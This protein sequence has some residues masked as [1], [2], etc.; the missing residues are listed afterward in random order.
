MKRSLCIVLLLA[1]GFARADDRGDQI[2]YWTTGY[3]GADLAGGQF[4]CKRPVFPPVS[5]TKEGIAAVQR[6]LDAWRD[7]YQRFAAN[8]NAR[9]D[10]GTRIPS[11]ALRMMTP[12]EVQQAQRHVD[13]VY[14]AVVERARKDAA[15]VAADEHAWQRATEYYVDNYGNPSSGIARVLRDAPGFASQRDLRV[16]NASLRMPALAPT[17]VLH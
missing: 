7:C 15:Q 3:Q 17:G 9:T 13:A 10:A 1:A 12:A 14:A 2:A 16:A 11:S 8:I 6:Q 5:K 4:A